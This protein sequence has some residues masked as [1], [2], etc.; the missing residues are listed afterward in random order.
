MRAIL[1]ELGIADV[2]L[3]P[4]RSGQFDIEVDGAVRYS[5]AQTRGFPNEAEVA[6]LVPEV[7]G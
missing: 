7:P 6:G 3:R 4:G 1:R 5:R 2:E